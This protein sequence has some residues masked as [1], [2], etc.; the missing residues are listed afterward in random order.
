MLARDRLSLST[1]SHL[2]VK[3]FFGYG[4][5][6]PCDRSFPNYIQIERSWISGFHKPL[7]F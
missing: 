2:L 3:V 5:N 7:T 4:E 6:N 1:M